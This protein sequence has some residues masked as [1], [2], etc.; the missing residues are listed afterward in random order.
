MSH[1]EAPL[2]SRSTYCPWI[3]VLGLIC[4]T[5]AAQTIDGE[6]GAARQ[7]YLPVI[8]MSLLPASAAGALNERIGHSSDR[9]S[10]KYGGAF[11]ITCRF[12]H[13]NADDP[14]VFP[15]Q[16]GRSHLHTYFGN[17]GTDAHTTA[18][19]LTSSGAST[20][21]GGILNRSAYWVPSMIDMRDGRPIKPIEMIV[22]YKVGHA[23]AANVVAPA[24]GLRMIAGD[25][26]RRGPAADEE[27]KGMLEFQCEDGQTPSGRHLPQKCSNRAPWNPT[28]GY[29]RMTIL[30]PQCWDG[31]NIDSPDHRSHMSYPTTSGC[32]S[33]H[34]HAIPEITLNVQFPVREADE[35]RHWRLSS[36][37]YALSIPGGYSVHADWW[38]GWNESI[39]KN[40]VANCL[41]LGLDCPMGNLNDGRALY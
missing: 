34:P 19:S 26:Q 15:G 40:V 29:L 3:G 17:T 27:P 32:P 11:R 4:V 6:K 7:S 25:P 8:N 23:A 1:L 21:S 41:R 18:N 22:Y 38:N 35:T 5:S 20:C 33:S 31:T 16:A 30:F 24:K 28:L 14:I 39:M 9:G 13:V 10:T 36:D 2:S 37:N 12:S